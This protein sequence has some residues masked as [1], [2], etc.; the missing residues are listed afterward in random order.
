MLVSEDCLRHYGKGHDD[1]PPGRGSG[2]YP[3]GSGKRPRQHE[4]EFSEI[5]IGPFGIDSE[6]ISAIKPLVKGTVK[7]VFKKATGGFKKDIREAYATNIKNANIEKGYQKR[8][9]KSVGIDTTNPEY[10]VIKNGAL[11]KRY[12]TNPNETNDSRKYA[13]LTSSDDEAYK[14]AALFGELG[15]ERGDKV[16]RYVMKAS[17]DLKVARADEVSKFIFEQ[18]RNEGVRRTY[19]FLNSI[20]HA[21]AF[22]TTAKLKNKS[23][24]LYEHNMGSYV[25]KGEQTVS[26]FFNDKVFSNPKGMDTLV[27]EFSNRGYDA[28]IDPEDQVLNYS[29]PIILLKPSESTETIKVQTV[30]PFKERGKNQNA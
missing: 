7:T 5:S 8:R 1:S 25:S 19:E 14:D 15:G 9:F 29:Y 27:K 24:D 20:D 12:S 6:V 10:D 28:I 23:D 4:E 11:I 26:R 3:W 21:N 18:Y 13:Y 16:Y 17:K 22:M 30:K 2:R